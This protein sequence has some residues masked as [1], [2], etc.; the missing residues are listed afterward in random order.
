MTV[1][2]TTSFAQPDVLEIGRYHEIPIAEAQQTV[3]PQNRVNASGI[4]PPAAPPQF[5]RDPRP[6]LARPL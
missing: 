5:R 3:L 6:S 2:K 1:K 4:H